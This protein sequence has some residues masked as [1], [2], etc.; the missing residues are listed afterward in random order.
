MK[1][2]TEK[3]NKQ[4][5]LGAVG[6]G[7]VF[8][9]YYLPALMRSSDWNLVAICEPL[10]D[11]RNW[12]QTRFQ[13]LCVFESFP[14]FLEKSAL[15]AVLIATP[16]T[17]HA[18]LAIQAL[19]MGHH[20]LVEKPMALD[21]AQASLMLE[22]SLRAQ[23][24]LW[25][26]FNRR[27]RL[28]YVRLRKK[29]AEVP[30]CSIEAIHFELIIDSQNWKSV[31]PYLGQDS[32]GGGVLDDV[33]SHQLDLLP[34]LIGQQVTAVKAERLAKTEAGLECACYELEF[35]N[36]L[37]AKC[38]AGH[39]PRYSENLEIQLGDRKLIVYPSG[40]LDGCSMPTSWRRTYCELRTFSHLA[41]RKLTRTPNVTLE[42]FE[43]QLSSFAAAIRGDRGS[44]YGT[45]AKSGIRSLQAIRA[46]RESIQLGGAWRS[47]SP[48]GDRI[49]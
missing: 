8:E 40:V 4:L 43:K 35:E 24:A 16:P 11:R 21:P 19:E 32:K 46:C 47:V 28:P 30:R 7:K 38:V 33:A 31:T 41:V 15:D 34:F 25:V 23:R 18:K 44:F 3:S 2:C 29:L 39:G 27:F 20:V 37:I 5:R 9:R 26:G 22:A 36:D 48:Q 13:E 45:D 6:C 10:K 17:T 14:A 42:S 49:S 1:N 12:A